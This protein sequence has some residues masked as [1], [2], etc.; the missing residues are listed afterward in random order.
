M[1][2]KKNLSAGIIFISIALL[3]ILAVALRIQNIKTEERVENFQHQLIAVCGAVKEAVVAAE[4]KEFDVYLNSYGRVVVW[5]T[6]KNGMRKGP[7]RYTVF[8]DGDVIIKKPYEDQAIEKSWKD[9]PDFA[10]I[11]KK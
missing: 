1:K 5:V 3:M 6:I 10:S 2:K 11:G 4:I 7:L 9:Y 8:R